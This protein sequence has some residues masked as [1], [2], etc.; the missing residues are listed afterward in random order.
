MIY[1]KKKEQK[2]LKILFNH[3]P[4]IKTLLT[5]AVTFTAAIKNLD[6]ALNKYFEQ[7]GVTLRTMRQIYTILMIVV[8]LPLT[9]VESS[10]TIEQRFKDG[11]LYFDFYKG[12]FFNDDYEDN[13]KLRKRYFMSWGFFEDIIL[14]S[15]FELKTNVSNSFQ[16][17]GTYIQRIRS[18]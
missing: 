2:F 3:Q 7:N 1:Q 11:P 6:T 18:I 13:S 10:S 14:G 16:S 12:T 5:S 17:E 9:K 8:G 4:D 15:F